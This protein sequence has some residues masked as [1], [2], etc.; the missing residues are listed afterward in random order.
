ML[1]RKPDHWPEDTEQW[2]LLV[3]KEQDPRDWVALGDKMAAAI[4]RG[5]VYKVQEGRNVL[6]V[7]VSALD[8]EREQRLS[9][10]NQILV[11]GEAVSPGWAV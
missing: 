5:Q 4:D 1:L 2:C 3:L 6:G 10:W 9:E 8:Q 11:N 7:A